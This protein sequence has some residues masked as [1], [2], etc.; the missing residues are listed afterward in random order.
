MQICCINPVQYIA[1][2]STD[3]AALHWSEA[4][5]E[6]DDPL[7]SLHQ[8]LWKQKHPHPDGLVPFE[9]SCQCTATISLQCI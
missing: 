2:L 1:A 5:G 4:M 3:F 7:Q 9:D 6:L 8:L